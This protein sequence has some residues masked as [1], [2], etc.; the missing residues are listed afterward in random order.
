MK[1]IFI[2]ILLFLLPSAWIFVSCDLE[3]A[4]TTDVSGSSLFDN[5]TSAKVALNGIYR[6]MYYFNEN[7]TDNY[8]QAFGVSAHVLVAEVMGEDLVQAAAGNGWF[9]S[10]CLYTA[11]NGISSTYGRPY[12]L[13]TSYYSWISNANYIIASQETMEGAQED[14]DYVVGQ[15]YAIRA[16]CY[17]YLAMLFSRTYIGHENEPCVPIYTEPTT[18]ETEGQPRATVQAVYKL[19][20]DDINTA[21]DMLQN[22]PSRDHKSHIN[23]YVANGIKA[24]ICLTTNNWSEAAAA[25]Q[26]ARGGASIGSSTDVLSGLNDIGLKNVLWGVEIIT[27]QSTGYGGLFSHMDKKGA[28]YA[29]NAPKQINRLLY[30]KMGATDIRRQ[31]WDVADD[32]NQVKLLYADPGDATGDY[33]WVRTEEMILTE[34][35]AQCRLGNE[36]A[37]RSLLM[38]LMAERDPEYTVTKTGTSLGNLTMD[39]TNSLLEEILVQRRIELWGEYGCIYDIKR[40]KQ[41]FTRTPEIGWPT[42]TLLNGTNTQNPETYAWVMTIPQAE[43]DANPNM[44]SSTDQNPLNDGI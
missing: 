41:G 2:Y 30:A 42:D 3:T 35:E 4:P 38:E 34:A 18:A 9:W 17:H 5:P 37:A 31:W 26:I 8:H 1:K 12:D 15:A 14:I 20:M 7:L 11:K 19:V 21:I 40:L 23:Y 27:D 16:Y 43:F 22:A 6:A 13:W 32:Y 29:T 24:R 10:D 44:D 28:R 33:L 39:W 36:P 25:A